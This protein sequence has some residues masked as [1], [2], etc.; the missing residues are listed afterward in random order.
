MQLKRGEERKDWS[1]PVSK[2]IS[3]PAQSM[4]LIHG[5]SVPTTSIV[6]LVTVI[7][8]IFNFLRYAEDYF[9]VI[10]NYVIIYYGVLGQY[11][12]PTLHHYKRQCWQKFS[13]FTISHLFPSRNSLAWLTPI[14]RPR[15]MVYTNPAAP[16]H[17]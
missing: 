9:N 15:C 4:L 10:L 5:S 2:L 14:L 13:I 16:L 12:N 6:T 8:R 7:A 1:V 17:G 3:S 11:A